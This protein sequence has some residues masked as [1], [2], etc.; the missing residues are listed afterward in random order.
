LIVAVLFAGE[1]GVLESNILDIGTISAL[2]RRRLNGIALRYP[3]TRDSDLQGEDNERNVFFKQT[4]LLE[5]NRIVRVNGELTS[6]RHSFGVAGGG[7]GGGAT[8]MD[9]SCSSLAQK[10]SFSA[11]SILRLS[12]AE[13]PTMRNKAKINNVAF[14]R[15]VVSC[16][17]T[18]L[19]FVLQNCLFGAG[20][21]RI[22]AG[23]AHHRILYM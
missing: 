20:C 22:G 18:E 7:V 9:L 14:V 10:S 2:S 8:D 17:A 6:T 13:P 12:A 1:S 5:D 11:T 21:R 23:L 15:I 19:D 16:F 4:D 3:H